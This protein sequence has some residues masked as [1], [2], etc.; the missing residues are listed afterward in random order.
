MSNRT[1]NSSIFL[2]FEYDWYIYTLFF[3]IA[4][5]CQT[6]SYDINIRHQSATSSSTPLTPTILMNS[7]WCRYLWHH[8]LFVPMSYQHTDVISI[9]WCHLN[10][11][12]AKLQLISDIPQ[13]LIFDIPSH[14]ISQL[15]FDIASD[16]QYRIRYSMSK[17]IF[18]IPTDSSSYLIST[19]IFTRVKLQLIF[20]IPPLIEI[21]ADIRYCL[22]VKLQLVFDIPPSLSSSQEGK[23]LS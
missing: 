1:M 8:I 15:I 10:S 12:R 22:L 2:L 14:L 5:G 11:T 6:S 7:K 9:H 16:I 3:N 20:V 21:P 4:R 19:S 23:V 17:L 18:D 13:E